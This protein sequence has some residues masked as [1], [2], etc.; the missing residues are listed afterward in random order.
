MKP[1]LAESVVSVTFGSP[2]SI[3]IELDD[4][5]PRIVDLAGDAARTGAHEEREQ[6]ALHREA[7]VR[8]DVVVA[9]PIEH[10]RREARVPGDEA[11]ER[12]RIAVRVVADVDRQRRRQRAMERRPRDA[13]AHA[14]VDRVVGDAGRDVNRADGLH[15]ERDGHAIGNTD[16]EQRTVRARLR[17]RCQR[18]AQRERVDIG[19]ELAVAVERLVDR[20]RRIEGDRRV[21]RH[22]RDR[23]RRWQRHRCDAPAARR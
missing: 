12:I 9:D 6:S 15:D 17:E 19:L 11:R 13:G 18:H 7:D 1:S 21:G 20:R 5:E 8:V 3:A 23:R 16:V 14:V 2:V 22:G 4:S 10:A